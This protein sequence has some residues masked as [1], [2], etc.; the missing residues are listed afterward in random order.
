M[1]VGENGLTGVDVEDHVALQHGVDLVEDEAVELIG[2]DEHLDPVLGGTL[3]FESPPVSG[4][5]DLLVA[6][7]GGGPG[8]GGVAQ[9]GAEL[10]AGP[11]WWRGRRRWPWRAGRPCRWPSV[12]Q[13]SLDGAW[14]LAPAALLAD[15]ISTAVVVHRLP[16]PMRLPTEWLPL[17]GCGVGIVGYARSGAGLLAR[18]PGRHR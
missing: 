18:A 14:F 4:G 7:P 11:D 3:A 1:A 2:A 13:G 8:V 9:Q 15:A 5:G 16:V 17:V 6:V 10:C 12:D